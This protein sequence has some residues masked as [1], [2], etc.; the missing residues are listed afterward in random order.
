MAPKLYSAD[1][2]LLAAAPDLAATVEALTA[3]RDAARAV[4]A[5]RAIIEARTVAPTD[6]EIAAHSDRGGLWLVRAEWR[7]GRHSI[8]FV[9]SW[10]PQIAKIL[11][12]H[13]GATWW[14]PLDSTG[15]P[16]AWPVVLPKDGAP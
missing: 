2:A 16:C 1:A 13:N 8:D 12:D 7:E 6:A 14:M 10:A 5:L 11:R 15:R 9:Q 4:V 3:E